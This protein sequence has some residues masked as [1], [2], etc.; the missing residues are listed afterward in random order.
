MKKKFI[1]VILIFSV[2]L[3]LVGKSYGFVRDD[4]E[5][6]DSGWKIRI[7]D[8]TQI[9]WGELTEKSDEMLDKLKE[10]FPNLTDNVLRNETVI[11]TQI[12]IMKY[13][14]SE[15]RVYIGD[16][17]TN[18]TKYS[19]GVTED[20]DPNATSIFDISDLK[21]I[22]GLNESVQESDLTDGYTWR[23]NIIAKVYKEDNDGSAAVKIK[24]LYAGSDIDKVY[25][26]DIDDTSWKED[27]MNIIEGGVELLDFI[28][29]A[30][31]WLGTNPLGALA[32]A[33]AHLPRTFG[34]ICQYWANIIQTLPDGNAGHFSVTYK[35]EE[36][37]TG[38]DKEYNKYTNVGGNNDETSTIK[39]INIKKDENGNGIDDFKKETP[40]PYVIV[41]FYT[42]GTG[43][44]DYFDINFLTGNK[45][46]KYGKDENG[47]K[48]EVKRHSSNSIWMRFRNI[49]A[50]LVKL[51]IYGTAS[52]LLVGLIWSGINIVRHTFDNPEAQAD[53]KKVIE[54]L[55]N[56]VF[57][58]I[59]SILVMAVCIYANEGVL[60][61]I[62]ESDTYE[63]PIRVNVEDVYSFSTT[64]AGY[65]RYMST[66]SDPDEAL[67]IIGSACEYM[68][69]AAANFAIAIIGIIRVLCVW[70]LSVVGPIMS[71]RYVF[72]KQKQIDLRIWAAAYAFAVL[73]Q[74]PIAFIGSVAVNIA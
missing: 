22:F 17:P 20:M 70:V 15:Y 28:K 68:V 29:T 1:A 37:T 56:A 64:H 9:K 4:F 47:N 45:S 16:N 67:Q 54:K 72:G 62:G 55:A 52:I 31:K 42:I 57:T 6:R 53:S 33:V 3:T 35:Y 63:L 5:D 69:L 65:A 46:T 30:K 41:D 18:I 59:G 11:E 10:Y 40:I 12:K 7:L 50:A 66:T 51:G 25:D 36:I 8:R 13:N 26:V 38:D 61:F 19:N 34:D 39:T 73:L 60:K 71:I 23:V 44:V 24:A 2:F 48:V 21:S 27:N 14:E 58:L 74:I 32:A 43:N 49:V